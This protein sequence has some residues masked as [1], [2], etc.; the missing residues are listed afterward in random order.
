MG[1]RA[2]AVFA[3][4]VLISITASTW[5]DALAQEA[6][7]PEAPVGHRQPKASDVPK[8]EP[9]YPPTKLLKNSTRPS[10]KN[11]RARYVA[12]A[13]GLPQVRIERDLERL[14]F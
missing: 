5:N 10:P 1:V 4:L 13:E 6:P 12:G 2:S 8:D 14:R 3:A 11:C 9:V 7:V